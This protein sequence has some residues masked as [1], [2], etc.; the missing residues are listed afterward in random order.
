M[1]TCF[2][3]QKPLALRVVKGGL[4]QEKILLLP[5]PQRQICH[6]WWVN[7]LGGC[8]SHQGETGLKW[9]VASLG[10]KGVCPTELCSAK[11]SLGQM[12][13]RV[14]WAASFSFPL[15]LFSGQLPF[16]QHVNVRTHLHVER[17]LKPTFYSAV[18]GTQ[19]SNNRYPEGNKCWKSYEV[20]KDHRICLFQTFLCFF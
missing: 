14:I 19:A 12:W 7:G 6:S 3:V 4:K 18:C 5:Y 8:P 10:G 9:G 16:F 13:Q 2:C 1:E 15:S 20:L 17:K 11:E